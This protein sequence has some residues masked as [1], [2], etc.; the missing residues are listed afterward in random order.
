MVKNI[1][2][3][4]TWPT[5]LL[6]WTNKTYPLHLEHKKLQERESFH[7]CN[8]I[9]LGHANMKGIKTYVTNQP[10]PSTEELQ[11]KESQPKC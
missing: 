8:N 9:Q 4:N 6:E 10:I 2:A 1:I 7:S 5:G 11:I 3:K